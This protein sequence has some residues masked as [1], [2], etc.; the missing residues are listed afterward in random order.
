MICTSSCRATTMFGPDAAIG[1]I[2]HRHS[3]ADK[4]L[5]LSSGIHQI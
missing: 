3:L 5:V 2:N 1:V 4:P